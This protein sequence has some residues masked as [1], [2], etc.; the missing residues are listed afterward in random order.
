[1]D[2]QIIICKR[3]GK[4]RKENLLYL[5]GQQ[6][7][8]LDKGFQLVTDYTFPY[9]GRSACKYQVTDIDGEIIGNISNHFIKAVD[10]K[11]GIALLNQLLI[12]IETEIEVFLV[13]DILK[14][15][16]FAD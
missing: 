11:A 15:Y 5:Q 16:P 13:L 1:M 3:K 12:L 6:A 10:H 7:V 14:G 2:K 4:I 9:A 8:I